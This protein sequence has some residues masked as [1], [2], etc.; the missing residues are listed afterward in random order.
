MS[1]QFADPG[2]VTGYHAHIY[3]EPETRALAAH[4]REGVAE[5]FQARVGNWHDEP[6]GPHTAAMYQL[7]FGVEEF[8]SLVP[9]LM[10]NRAGLSVLVHPMTGDA[11]ADHTTHALWLGPSL[12]VKEDVLRRARG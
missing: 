8:P 5:R 3:Y 7:A 11:L 10:L 1:T 9:W 12:P 2:E 6:V 4:L